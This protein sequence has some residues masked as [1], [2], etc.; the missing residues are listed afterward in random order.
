M[1]QPHHLLL[2]DTLHNHECFPKEQEYLTWNIDV[3][4]PFVRF[5]QGEKMSLRLTEGPGGKRSTQA[6][7]ANPR[8]EAVITRQG[9][10]TMT[11]CTA[12]KDGWWLL[13]CT[14]DPITKILRMWRVLSPSLSHAYFAPVVSFS[15]FS[16]PTARAGRRTAKCQYSLRAD[17]HILLCPF[18]LGQGMVVVNTE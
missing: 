12:T 9:R 15:C 4:I 17:L 6:S 13:R 7:W 1:K 14:R 11:S 8:N 18:I 5:I 16:I 10:F 2:R 3:D